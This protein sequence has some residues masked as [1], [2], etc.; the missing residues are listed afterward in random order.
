M[1]PV[2]VPGEPRDV[3]VQLL[4]KVYGLADGTRE[5]RNCL[6][7]IR[8]V[9]FG[10]EKATTGIPWYHWCGCRRHCWRGTRSLG[11]VHQQR[12]T[13]EHWEVVKILAVEKSRKQLMD[14]CASGSLPISRVWISCLSGN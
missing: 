12:F 7:A 9:C 4:K 5:W 1:P 8:T 10:A 13:L 14:P 2:G 6:L 3:W 11:T